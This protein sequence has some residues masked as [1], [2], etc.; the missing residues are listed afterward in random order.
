MKSI[1]CYNIL[2]V[3]AVI[4]GLIGVLVL[5]D[6]RIQMLLGIMVVCVLVELLLHWKA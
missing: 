6:I 4:V 2:R 5:D 3:C 1:L